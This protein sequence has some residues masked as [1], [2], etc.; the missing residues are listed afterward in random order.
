MC[1]EDSDNPK[2]AAEA[3]RCYQEAA[4]RMVKRLRNIT[5]GCDTKRG[6]GGVR[7]D[8]ALSRCVVREQVNNT[9]LIFQCVVQGSTFEDI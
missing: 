1:S 6:Y 2:G 4:E 5:S 7:K 8:E 9:T 3:L